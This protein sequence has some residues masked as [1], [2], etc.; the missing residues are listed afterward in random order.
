MEIK[1]P[2]GRGP[3]PNYNLVVKKK[4]C[5]DE[6]NGLVKVM[7]KRGFSIH[8]YIMSYYYSLFNVEFTL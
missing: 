4:R 8:Q 3:Y 2:M 6:W 1:R 5:I 7:K